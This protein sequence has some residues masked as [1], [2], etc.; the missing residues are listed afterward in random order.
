MAF[1]ASTLA[2]TTYFDNAA[3][4]TPLPDV[5]EEL[6][7]VTESVIGNSS[8][9]HRRGR[10]AQEV[11][12][13]CH[14]ALGRFFEVP[15]SHVIFTSGGT[16]SNN[17]AVWGALGGLA[18]AFKSIKAATSARL[19]TSTIEHSSLGRVYETLQE[20][21]APVYFAGVNREGLLDLSQFEKAL[22]GR[23]RLVSLHHVQSEI[24]VVQD[25]KA[26]SDLIRA[27]QPDALLHI[28]AVQSYLK[29]PVSF[30]GLGVDMISISGHKLGGPKG[31]G[32][33]ILGPRFE[34]RRP[35][36]GQFA[37]GAAH[38]FGIRPGTVPVPAIAAMTSAIKWGQ[39]HFEE[40]QQKLLRLRGRLFSKLPERA[41]P[42]G[43]S[44]ISEKNPGRA[45]QIVNFSI[46]GLPSAVVVEELS[47]RNFCVSAGS[48][49]HST[50]PQPNATLMQMG[51]GPERAL[52]AVRVSFSPF[53]T[54]EEVDHFV[55]ELRD[56]IEQVSL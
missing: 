56:V 27:K 5:V 41:R 33:L 42:N 4:T 30:A 2:G 36:L 37:V 34:G 45:P 3:T 24:G 54:V 32:A 14:E 21:G 8:S 49:C 11:L 19:V 7:R 38:Q 25:I 39:A 6:H 28:D 35:K 53:N 16:E 44:D 47:A 20:I 17:L 50:N 43:P 13:Q 55:D 10:Q 18:Q 22:D 15:P 12:D 48:A 29:V 9:V 26:A 52:S 51:L 31:V 1:V 23:T 46:P 40:N